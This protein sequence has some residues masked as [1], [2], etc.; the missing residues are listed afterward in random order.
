MKSIGEMMMMMM[1][2]DGTSPVVHGNV[3]S[4]ELFNSRLSICM[5][6]LIP[7]MPIVAYRLSEEVR[8]PG[9]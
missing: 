9:A 5:K 8:V 3:F 7:T 4:A 2:P 6:V 1:M